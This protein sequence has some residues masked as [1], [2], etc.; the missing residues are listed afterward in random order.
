MAKRMVTCTIST[1]EMLGSTC[2]QVM[3]QGPLPQ[4]RAARMYSRPH[5]DLA[6]PR[7]SRVKVG[8]L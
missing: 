4:A 6:A 1:A 3:A 8:M 7:A 5:T 2:C